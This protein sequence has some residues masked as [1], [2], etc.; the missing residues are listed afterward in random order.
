MLLKSG[1]NN[2][3]K[4]SELLEIF[5]DGSIKPKCIMDKNPFFVHTFLLN[6]SNK[7]RYTTVLRFETGLDISA[8]SIAEFE[9]A[10]QTNVFYFIQ[11]YSAQL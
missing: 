10:E 8:M 6:I 11:K 7:H 3:V 4:K 1:T 2:S 9:V 5:G